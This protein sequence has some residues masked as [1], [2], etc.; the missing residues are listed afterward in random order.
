MK[1][2]KL[3]AAA[4][5]HELAERD[6]SQRRVVSAAE[7][8]YWNK[9]H[10]NW[11]VKFIQNPSRAGSARQRRIRCPANNPQWTISSTKSSP[12]PKPNRYRWQ[13]DDASFLRR[14]TL[15]GC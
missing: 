7:D 14:V 15:P 11:R 9:R 5:E 3:F 8:K 1:E 13:T 10:E 4:Q 12:P 2:W 6:V